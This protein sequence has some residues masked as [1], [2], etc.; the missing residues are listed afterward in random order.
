LV[1]DIT[2][3]NRSTVGLNVLNTISGAVIRAQKTLASSGTLVWEGAASGASLYIAS[4]IRG[5]GLTD[6]DAAGVSKLLWDATTGRFSCGTDATAAD[7]LD[8]STADARYVQ[9]QG[10]TMTGALTINITN[11]TQS[12]IGLNVLNT[13]SGAVIRAQKTLASS[14][15]LVFEGAASG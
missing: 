5:A 10:D 9:K 7:G 4:S 8:I 13:I 2:G 1:I 14:G 15:S 12:T 11:G 6:C 3:G